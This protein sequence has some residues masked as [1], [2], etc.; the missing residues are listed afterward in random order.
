M[1]IVS[2]GTLG[3]TYLI[4][5]SENFYRNIILK[6]Y[7]LKLINFKVQAI[8]KTHTHN[9]A[10]SKALNLFQNVK[11]A[12]NSKSSLWNYCTI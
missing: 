11:Q 2:I 5:K 3:Q 8:L 4:F 12:E 1:D 9:Q 6:S 10:K 7:S